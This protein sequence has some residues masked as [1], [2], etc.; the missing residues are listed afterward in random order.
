[1]TDVT[2]GDVISQINFTGGFPTH[3]D[4]A[5]SI[6]FLAAYALTTPLLI[7]RLV[8]SQDRTVLLVRPSVFVAARFGMLVVRI[9]MAKGTYS[10]GLLIA[11]LVL[12]SVGFLFLIEPCVSLWSR[13]IKWTLHTQAEPRWV[14]RIRTLLTVALLA[15]ISISA[16]SG[17]LINNAYTQP[18]GIDKVKHMR[19]A[20]YILSLGQSPFPLRSK[21][22]S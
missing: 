13:N 8:R 16:A 9:I 3:K 12:V 10:L 7:F 19:E 6:I 5:P 11:E 22:Q 2:G 1:M 15:A 18:G 14:K 21:P 17:A 20:G 4:L